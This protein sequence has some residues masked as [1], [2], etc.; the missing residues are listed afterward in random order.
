MAKWLSFQTGISSSFLLKPL[1]TFEMP[2]LLESWKL[3]YACH[4][5]RSTIFVGHLGTLLVYF[6]SVVYL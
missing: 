6:E 1:A 3:D 2:Y 5:D 4:S